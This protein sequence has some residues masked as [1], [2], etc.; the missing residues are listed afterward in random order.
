[1]PMRAAIFPP[2][3]S[4]ALCLPVMPGHT[5]CCTRH[6][7]PSQQASRF[8]ASQSENPLQEVSLNHHP[9]LPTSLATMSLAQGLPRDMRLRI[10][11]SHAPTLAMDFE[12]VSKPCILLSR[13]PCACPNHTC[14]FKNIQEWSD[15]LNILTWKCV[16]C[17]NVPHFSNISVSKTGP[18]RVCF[19]TFWLRTFFRVTTA[20]FLST[21]QVGKGPEPGGF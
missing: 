3:L 20:F 2:H 10:F 21:S 1:M 6:T 14:T 9:D 5:K 18:R 11:S 4:T 17:H 12:N 19:K 13:I 7:K 16:S 15:H 8:D